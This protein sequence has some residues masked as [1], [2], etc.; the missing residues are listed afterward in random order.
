MA[1]VSIAVI[2][3]GLFGRKHI[4][5]MQKEPA[6]RLAAIADPTPEADTDEPEARP[7]DKN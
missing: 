3:A 4:E 5:I 7:E 2:G 1:Q 6:C